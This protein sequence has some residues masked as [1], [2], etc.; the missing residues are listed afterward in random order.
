[1]VPTPSPVTLEVVALVLDKLPGLLTALGVMITS[2]ASIIAARRSGKNLAVSNGHN[3]ALVAKVDRLEG[4]L[5]A[6]V[7]AAKD[8]ADAARQSASD[9]RA[10]RLETPP[11]AAPLPGTE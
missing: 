1:M 10:A 11:T 7:A 9:V 5:A 2:A 4:Q 3:A 6:V 8:A